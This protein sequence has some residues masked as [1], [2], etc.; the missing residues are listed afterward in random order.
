[1]GGRLGFEGLR[2]GEVY[3]VLREMEAEGTVAAARD[4][5]EDVG[6]LWRRYEV[7]AAGEAYLLES[8]ADD[9]LERNRDETE[10]FLRAYAGWGRG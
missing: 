2:P 8:C 1:M 3:R 7:T 5:G 4:G 9:S 6:P 10:L